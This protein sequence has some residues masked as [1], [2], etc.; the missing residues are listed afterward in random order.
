[1]QVVHVAPHP[2]DELTGAPATLMA[3]RDA[4]HPVLNLA[5][6]LGRPEGHARREHEVRAATRRA[7]FELELPAT[8]VPLS[9]GDD[10]DAGQARV[11]AL[12]AE[13]VDRRGAGIVVSPSP[14][15]GHP[16][17][18]VVGRAV[19]QVLAERPGVRWWMWGLW[20]DLPLPTVLVPFD[21]ARLGEIAHALEAHA[22]ELARNDYRAL[23]HGRGTANRVL[24]PERVFGY[25]TGGEAMPYAELVTEV[26]RVDGAWRLGAPVRLTGEPPPPEPGIDVGWWLDAPSIAERLAATGG[27]PGRPR[28]LAERGSRR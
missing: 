13:L 25:G 20:A 2:D 24:G 12:V 21:A 27:P 9:T 14:H 18:E 16:G 22:G 3:L 19:R 11:A 23:L 4:G 6:G 28:D 10:L 5:C 17:H 15:D 8:P 7:G 26:L 1:V